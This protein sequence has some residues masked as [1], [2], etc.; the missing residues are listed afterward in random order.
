MKTYKKLIPRIVKEKT[1]YYI[2]ECKV[3]NEEVFGWYRLK[4]TQNLKEAME[5]MVD[6][7][8]DNEIF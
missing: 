3:V 6:Q 8:F 1:F 2:D 7:T 5:L 4:E